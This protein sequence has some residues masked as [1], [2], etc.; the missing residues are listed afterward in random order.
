MTKSKN[1]R[2][3]MR[4]TDAEIETFI[5]DSRTALL[6]S[7]GPRGYPHVTPLWYSFRDGKFFFETHS[8]SQKV[9]NIRRDDMVTVTIEGGYTYDQLRGISVEGKAKIIEDPQELWQ[10][11]VSEWERYQGPYDESARDKVEAMLHRRVGIE[12][13]I[14][15]IRSWDHRKLGM[16]RPPLTGSTAKQFI[17]ELREFLD[18]QS[19]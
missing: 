1:P 15:R 17:Q 10:I 3:A 14:M 16:E 12:V 4:M 2:A 18:E 11:G 7:N 13:E 9:L 5:Q 6:A 19:S 8:K